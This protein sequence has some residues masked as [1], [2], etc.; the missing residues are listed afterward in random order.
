MCALFSDCLGVNWPHLSLP[1]YLTSLHSISSYVEVM[2]EPG[3]W[4]RTWCVPHIIIIIIIIHLI[5]CCL[6]EHLILTLV[7]TTWNINSASNPT[8][9]LVQLAP[10]PLL[11]FFWSYTHLSL[12]SAFLLKFSYNCTFFFRYDYYLLMYT[13]EFLCILSSFPDSSV[14]KESTW[15]AGDPGLIPGWGRSPGEGIG[16]PL[17]YSRASLVVQQLKNPPAIWDSWVWSLGWKDPLGRG[18][19]STPVFWPGE[20]LDMTSEQLSL[21]VLIILIFVSSPKL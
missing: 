19:L 2:I 16:Y 5:L 10:T 8:L 9:N 15:N 17:Q 12:D 7:S 14:G 4:K 11:D 1:L 20:S 13:F 18:R 3:L 6:S 21:W